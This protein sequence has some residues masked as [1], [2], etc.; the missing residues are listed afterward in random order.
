MRGKRGLK[1]Y[2]MNERKNP[3]IMA[4]TNRIPRNY[5]RSPPAK[6]M[7]IVSRRYWRK[8]N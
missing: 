6:L 8:N 1:N 5:I 7:I 2:K 4:E 3:W